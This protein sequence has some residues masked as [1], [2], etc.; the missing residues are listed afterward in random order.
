[1][2]G[3]RPVSRRFRLLTVALVVVVGILAFASS[4]HDRRPA[5]NAVRTVTY[6]GFGD[7]TFAIHKPSGDPDESVILY[8]RCADAP[9]RRGAPCS[10]TLV[11]G[12]GQRIDTPVRGSAG[13]EG[14]VLIDPDE[15]SQTKRLTVT[16]PAH[17]QVELRP[18]SRARA[19]TSVAR[20]NGDEVLRYDGRA[21]HAFVGHAAVNAPFIIETIVADEPEALLQVT[22]AFSGRIT[23]PGPGLLMVTTRGPWSIT[24]TADRAPSGPA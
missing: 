5:H 7:R 16:A 20:G 17:W 24:T 19:F 3:R 14:S 4:G 1:M 13:Y 12:T 15:G 23:L 21:S 22:G 9:G 11:S 18:V 8:A 2:S 10:V 6:A